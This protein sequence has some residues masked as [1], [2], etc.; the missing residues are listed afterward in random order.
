MNSCTNLILQRYIFRYLCEM[1]SN[2]DPCTFKALASFG[3]KR[4][5]S[6]RTE[7]SFRFTISSILNNLKRRETL[8]KRLFEWWCSRS[9]LT[10][11][12]LSL[13]LLVYLFLY[14]ILYLFSW[15]MHTCD[16][17][18]GGHYLFVTF[19]VS[20]IAMCPVQCIPP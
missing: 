15:K 1:R 3:M 10:K 12:K 19:K 5:G 2:Y 16:K 9:E 7:I 17:K 11:Y 18:I 13:G 6:S 8:Y 14:T 20:L 4:L